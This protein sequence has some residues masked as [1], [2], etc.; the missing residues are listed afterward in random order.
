MKIFTRL[1][2]LSCFYIAAFGVVLIYD[3]VNTERVFDTILFEHENLSAEREISNMIQKS[4]LGIQS[5]F[6]DLSRTEKLNQAELLRDK[7][8]A[9]ADD[10]DRHL[11]V[12]EGGGTAEYILRS[13]NQRMLSVDYEAP[14]EDAEEVHLEYL[15]IKAANKEIR[16]AVDDLVTTVERR[17]AY[18]AAGETRRAD[19]L[20]RRLQQSLLQVGPILT[21]ALERANEIYIDAVKTQAQSK[22]F[23]DKKITR[24]RLTKLILSLVTVLGVLLIATLISGSITRKIKRSAA[25][26]AGIADGDLSRRI[27][28]N[29]NGGT[30][31]D[32]LANL[33][34]SLETMR[35][36]MHAVIAE[37]MNSTDKSTSVSGELR[38]VSDATAYSSRRLAF[39]S[40][41]LKEEVAHQQN[42]STETLVS[43]RRIISSITDLHQAVQDDAA[44][45]EESSAAV[46]QMV[47]NIKSMERNSAELIEES[48]RLHHA[49]GLGKENQ[50]KL[51]E[52]VH[53]VRKLSSELEKMNKLVSDIAAE[54]NLLSMNA[55]IEAAHAGERGKGFA[56]VASEIRKLATT[57]TENSK[58]ISGLLRDVTKAVKGAAEYAE[59]ATFSFTEIGNA[60]EGVENVAK[61]TGQALSE[62]V[63]GA[64][65]I[66]KA[67]SLLR[68]STHTVSEATST[69]TT[70][71]DDVGENA[72]KLSASVK[73][74]DNAAGEIEDTVKNI[75]ESIE[76]LNRLSITNNEAAGLVEERVSTFIL[77]ES[78]EG[79]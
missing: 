57:T 30:R 13:N 4:L 78:A 46:E 22:V 55:A 76:M 36:S 72:D 23:I 12:L 63:T 17:V 41:K 14:K 40:H 27:L 43:I 64:E 77:S 69:I 79:G 11:T 71:I 16:S 33:L 3:I 26:V 68:E 39:T 50:A 18:E 49:T 9:M 29:H 2:L 20:G 54:I 65:E 6:G 45:T 21:R 42:L 56:V 24:L 75:E 53:Q 67:I 74:V 1:L 25:A 37:V 15:E 58:L 35:R 70:A 31:K 59:E 38:K 44:M 10:V 66:F 73:S 61:H 60:V 47:A 48:Q 7:I 34:L 5:M 28:A 52:A 19:I 8:V 62:Q 51:T 32:E